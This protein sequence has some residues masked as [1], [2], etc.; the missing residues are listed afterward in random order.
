MK[1]CWL[2]LWTMGLVLI[3]ASALSAGELYQTIQFSPSEIGV[4]QADGYQRVTVP[5]AVVTGAPGSPEVPCLPVMMAIPPTATLEKVEVV[6][7]EQGI[8]P[9]S[10]TLHPAQPPTTFS[11]PAPAF[12]GPDPVVYN[13]TKPLPGHYIEEAG[14]GTKCG[15]RIGAAR[16]YPVQ[17]V[18]ATKQIL[19]AR[20]IVLK[21]TYKEGT[22]ASEV[23]SPGQ[24]RMFGDD[25]RWLVSNPQ[26]VARFAPPLRLP[27][28]AGSAFLPPGSFSEV[29]ISTTVNSGAL[30]GLRDTLAK[31]VTWRSK[32]G[33]RC[34]LLTQEDI[35]ATYA[36]RDTAERIRNFI[37]DARTTWGTSMFFIASRDV[38]PSKAQHNWRRAYGPVSGYQEQFPA[39]LYFSD[40]NGSWDGDRDNIFG[41]AT[42][43]I[44]GYSDVYIGRITLDSTIEASKYLRRMFTYEK[45]PGAGFYQK[46]FLTNDVTFSNEYNDTI[47]T[48]T[49]TPPWLDC[50]MYATGGDVAITPQGFR[51]TLNAGWMYTAHIGHGAPNAMGS[52]YDCTHAIAQSNVGKPELIIAVCC[53]PGAF[54]TSG[55]SG[56]LNG[57][58]LAENMITHAVNGWVAVMFN[59]RYG[60]VQVAES[61]NIRFFESMLPAPQRN[62]LR[63]GQCLGRAKDFFVPLW[64]DATWG[65][66]HRWECYEKNLFGDPGVPLWNGAQPTNLTVSYPAVVPVG[67]SAFTV[68]VNGDKAQIRGARVCA[69]KGGETY[70]TDTTDATG[71]VIL[72]ISPLTP[73]NLDVTVTAR[74][75]LPWEGTALVRSSGAYVGVLRTSINDPGPGGNG[76]GIINPSETVFMPTWVKNFGTQPANNVVAKLRST[77]SYA[78]VLDSVANC[79]N[80][81]AGDSF[82]I[83]PGYRFTAAPSC[84]NGVALTFNIV[85]RDAN[86]SIWTTPVSKTVGTAVLGYESYWTA[87]ANHRLDPGDSTQ[88]RIVLRNSGFGN[89]YNV[90]GTLRCADSRITITDSLGTYGSIPHDTTGVNDAD[91][92]TVK[93]SS[94][95]P[96][97]TPIPFV[98]HLVADGG[99]VVDRSFTIVVG[100]ITAE[101]PQGPDPYGYYAYESTDSMYLNRPT[102]SWIELNPSRGGNGTTVGISGDDMSLRQLMRGTGGI[103][104]R[105]YGATSD[106]AT[107]CT[108]AWLSI[109]RTTYAYYSNAALPSTSFVPNGV[110]IFWD[111]LTVSGTGTCWY[112][113]DANQRFIVEWDSVPT[114][115]G[116][117]AG[118]FEIIVMDTSLTPGTAN[119]RDSEIILQWKNASAISSMTVG[120]QNAAMTVGLCPFNNGTY[121]RGMGAI[122]GGKALKFTTDPPR[123]VS[124][125]ELEVATPRALPTAYGLA[126]SRPNPL[127][128]RALIGY[129]LPKDSK[130]ALRVYNVSGQMVRELVNSEEKAGWKE[131]AWDGRDAKGHVLSSGVY[132]YRLEASGYTATRKL[133]VVR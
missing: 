125:V 2:C 3:L 83:N 118:T 114:L 97:E 88:M 120:Q 7:L 16:L 15:F 49:P 62:Y 19:F 94:S 92:Y 61:Y 24:I 113:R 25:V 111:D 75:F 109:A 14:T 81:A 17:Y 58:C 13:S 69:M 32:A 5:R 122:V 54:D 59:S 47:R 56:M 106:S 80:L 26:D 20:R 23:A 52:L 102:Y 91:R 41:E 35:A 66:R 10:Y 63:L 6:D 78:T 29:V 127:T 70:A 99:Y 45:T 77:T 42:D 104:V 76:D 74:N 1:R 18:P 9:G 44:D 36:G 112:R 38:A 12:V 28:F 21:F 22:V 43:S 68:T 103:R 95:I 87:D 4:S 46:A 98:V 121:D 40:L 79:G 39:D 34:T 115:G 86:D 90:R 124:G 117:Y 53:H 8:L 50:R 71:S 60:W 133:V 119:T 129:A 31:L 130:V 93:A 11:G 89:G 72:N 73:G 101:D 67:P 108:N 33:V 107:I 85:C 100:T 110:A 128:N 48:I 96:K 55:V 131:A 57:D 84:T 30:T 116:S 65:D 37:K 126:Q 64:T 105:H 27:G 132:F 82:Y 51:D 123:M